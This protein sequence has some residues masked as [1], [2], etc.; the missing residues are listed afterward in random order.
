MGVAALVAITWGN[1][2]YAVQ[3]GGGNDFL[4]HWM[5]AR[6]L[7]EDG[8]SPYSDEVAVKIQTF[9]YGRPARAGEHQLRVAY[10]LY[11][12]FL[13]APFAA[14]K[15]FDWARAAWMT[16]LEAGLVGLVFLSLSLC[17][18]KPRPLVLALLL[19]FSVFW[20]HGLR[21]LINGNAV[22]LVA[23]LLTGGLLAMRS[24]A[25]ELAGVLFAFS[26]IKP[27]VVVLFLAYI[28]V[29]SIGH[30]RWRVVG[31]LFGVTFLLAT[32]AALI[33]PDWVVQNLREVMLYPSYN[34]PGTPAAAF[35]T[36]WPAF[37]RRLGWAL[38]GLMG[39]VLIAE[40]WAARKGETRHFLWACAITL[41]AAQWI[42]IQTDPGNFIVLFPAL[43]MALG[44]LDEHWRGR[45][46]IPIILILL[47]LFGGLWG[48]FLGTV[49]YADQPIQS[50]VMFFPLPAMMFLLL[51]W[52]R[53]W[54]VRPPRPWLEQIEF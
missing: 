34:P 37:G 18:W 21:P 36:W 10:P 25:D 22:I 27:Q 45:G 42:G 33:L 3:N 29:W 35:L 39:L 30:R 50:P 17:R 2:N 7:L 32:S 11:S 46:A 15:D 13:F 44:L 28:V 19:L 20:Y 48:I 4:V 49:E 52:V 54:A 12:V 8:I 24:G 5:G 31:W 41:T 1:H 40:W 14:I 26:T 53:W 51:Y 16:V 47:V 23:V 43:V 9:A 6:A 38:T